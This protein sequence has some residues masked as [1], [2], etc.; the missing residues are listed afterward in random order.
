M[1]TEATPAPIPG[2]GPHIAGSPW[3]LD[4]EPRTV[5]GTNLAPSEDDADA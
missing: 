1:P 4:N 2:N 5:P 3:L